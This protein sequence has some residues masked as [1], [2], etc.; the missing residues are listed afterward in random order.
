MLE[1]IL[2]K[3]T[4]HAAYDDSLADA[5]SFAAESGFA[6][7]Q[8]ALEAPQFFF[9][10]YAPQ[11]LAEIVGV[12]NRHKS[13]VSLHGPS[14]MCSLYE[15]NLY[16]GQGIFN[17]F[18]AMCTFAHKI[19]AGTL[20]LHLGSTTAF[21]SDD[22]PS[23][24]MPRN[25]LAFY[26]TTLRENFQRLVDLV[27]GRFTV[28]VEL[29]DLNLTA[30]DILQPFLDAGKVF[31]CWDIA[32]MYNQKMM[33][34]QQLEEYFW[35]NLPKVR[36]V[37]LHDVRDGNHYCVVGSGEIDFSRYLP[38]LAEADVLEY[39][40]EVHPREK[41]QKSLDNLKSIIYGLQHSGKAD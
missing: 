20:V 3:V 27:A 13:L 16:L 37:H 30:M 29:F 34:N 41:A 17:Y 2:K 39:C 8:V 28:C 9:E 11:Q 36:Q 33:C 14:Q 21:R 22:A 15:G 6:G 12:R 31:L 10:K 40:I 23:L 26:R 32:R 38:R 25:M 35:S 7:V 4:Y 19:G 18:R 5:L 1:N 24:Q